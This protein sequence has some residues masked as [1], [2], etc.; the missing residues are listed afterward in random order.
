MPQTTDPVLFRNISSFSLFVQVEDVA[1][2]LETGEPSAI[3]ANLAP[4]E[5][6]ELPVGPAAAWA[7]RGPLRQ[8]VAAGRGPGGGAEVAVDDDAIARLALDPALTTFTNRSGHAAVVFRDDPDSGLTV[9]CDLPIGHYVRQRTHLGERWEV[10]TENEFAPIARLTVTTP[11]ERRCLVE[12][13][14]LGIANESHLHLTVLR[15]DGDHEHAVGHV[16]PRRHLR[17]ANLDPAPLLVRESATGAVVARLGAAAGRRSVAITSHGIRT[18][19]D[20]EPVTLTVANDFAFDL[21]VGEARGTPAARAPGAT[22]VRVAPGAT[23]RLATRRGAL[24]RAHEPLTGVVVAE[25]VVPAPSRARPSALTVARFAPLGKGDSSLGGVPTV[26]IRS[27]YG[28]EN[29]TRLTLALSRVVGGGEEDEGLLRPNEHARLWSEEGDQWVVRDVD[30][31][32]VVLMPQGA[33]DLRFLRIT[34]RMLRSGDSAGTTTVTATNVTPHDLSIRRHDRRGVAKET[35]VIAVGES[36]TFP[37]EPDSV[38]SA[39]ATG[40]GELQANWIARRDLGPQTWAIRLRAPASGPATTVDIHVRAATSVLVAK[41]DEDGDE[42]AVTRL[43]QHD[44][45]PLA[46]RVGDPIIVRDQRSNRVIAVTVAASVPTTLVVTGEDARSTA[47]PGRR[48]TTVTFVNSSGLAADVYWVDWEGKEQHAASLARDRRTVIDGGTTDVFRVRSHGGAVQR[49]P[50]A[51]SAAVVLGRQVG[52]VAWRTASDARPPVYERDLSEVDFRARIDALAAS[53][54][55]VAHMDVVA[56]RTGPRYSAVWEPADGAR[57]TVSLGLT[58]REAIETI[59]ETIGDGAR[60]P[61]RVVG[62]QGADGARFAV[63]FRAVGDAERRGHDLD[64][65]REMFGKAPGY[66]I[67]PTTDGFSAWVY[68]RDNQHSLAVH[69]GVEPAVVDRLIGRDGASLVALSGFETPDG[70]R[71]CAIAQRGVAATAAAHGLDEAAF[72]DRDARERAAGR[73]ITDLSCYADGRDVRHAALWRPAPEDGLPPLT[74]LSAGGLE[75]ALDSGRGGVLDLAYLRQADA[76]TVAVTNTLVR[77]AMRPDGSLRPGEVALFERPNF[78]GRVWI[79]HEDFADFTLLEGMNDVV[80]SLKVGPGTGVTLYRDVSFDGPAA[81][82]H[83]DVPDLGRAGF[84]NGIASSAALWTTPSPAA[85]GIT[86]RSALTNEHR[87][88]RS[89]GQARHVPT[90]VFRA[91]VA[92]PPAVRLVDVWASEPMTIQVAGEAYTIDAQ[93]PARLQP[94]RLSRIVISAPADALHVPELQLRTNTME[95]DQRLPVYLDSSFHRKLA[96]MPTGTLRANRAALNIHADLSDDAVDHVET[97]VRNLARSVQYR[98]APSVNGVHHARHVA[99]GDMEH[100]HWSL[101]FDQPAAGRPDPA[102]TALSTQEAAAHKARWDAAGG[103]L[104]ISVLGPQGI[105]DAFIHSIEN[106]GKTLWSGVKIIAVTVEKEVVTAAET[107]ANV[108]RDGVEMVEHLGKDAVASFAPF[109][110]DLVHGDL[111]H[112]ANDLGHG[113]LNFGAHAA[114][115]VVDGVVNVAED[116]GTGLAEEAG[117]LLK[118]SEQ[119]LALGLKFGAQEVHIMA[120]ELGPISTLVTSLLDWAGAGVGN[121]VRHM[122]TDVDWHEAMRI[123]QELGAHTEGFLTDAAASAAAFQAQGD[124]FFA[125]AAHQIGDELDAAAKALDP[126]VRLHRSPPGGFSEVMET[127]ESILSKLADPDDDGPT[128]LP[129]LDLSA[130][131]TLSDP[132][133]RMIAHMEATLGQEG[134]KLEALLGD[135]FARISDLLGS[136]HASTNQI[137]AELLELVKDVDRA[138][139]SIVGTTF[140]LAMEAVE[141]TFGILGTALAERMEVPFFSGLY[142][143]LTAGETDLGALNLGALLVAIPAAMMAD[144]LDKSPLGLGVSLAQSVPPGQTD[145]PDVPATNEAS[146]LPAEERIVVGFGITYAACHAVLGLLEAA[147]TVNGMSGVEDLKAVRAGEQARSFDRVG[148]TLSL[149]SLVPSITSQVVANPTERPCGPP[150]FAGLEP[151]NGRRVLRAP[152]YVAHVTWVLQIVELVF[153]A[154]ERIAVAFDSGRGNGKGGQARQDL[155]EGAAGVSDVG[156]GLITLYGLAHLVCFIVLR[157]RDDEKAERLSMLRTFRLEGLS[158]RDLLESLE[159]AGLQISPEDRAE[160]VA[161]LQDPKLLTDAQV[162]ELIGDYTAFKQWADR[163]DT[164]GLKLAANVMDSVP[165][166]GAFMTIERVMAAAPEI[167][168]PLALAVIGG[169]HLAEAGAYAVRLQQDELRYRSV[170][171]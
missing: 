61:D 143:A 132:L 1:A 53:S 51:I 169:G 9:V 139:L 141:G 103:A 100:A 157:I 155:L 105:F 125:D 62:Y 3:G 148:A 8:E 122:L 23:A 36:L 161:R 115:D 92:F 171:S 83:L 144:S 102:Y 5:E 66:R 158:G 88:D 135:G 170:P 149:V 87:V 108:A 120:T 55:Q 109:A 129:D 75:A 60:L 56:T 91:S 22:T 39:V 107:V 81:S 112:A 123:A 31:G 46:C 10:L 86:S 118:E 163:G 134:E 138:G 12:N 147:N 168:L 19:E 69:A 76:Q 117:H 90:P 48:A 85:L 26:A 154:L 97:A 150:S 151:I 89:S 4:G 82:F 67:I 45:Y 30:S 54:L 119:M 78:G 133:G 6:R 77:T 50:G 44:S 130:A 70:V 35:A 64:K 95:S 20:A 106:V 18:A 32:R 43:D 114:E 71:M 101:S 80:A 38:W 52:A 29:R 128:T 110:E 99:A 146:D 162:T 49:R 113:L 7:V 33:R 47:G 2:E 136:E 159:T 165:E 84:L 42:I 24:I 74:G 11:G 15:P 34:P 68:L 153:E 121:L 21:D 28:F 63:S 41:A 104:P 111:A 140:D 98:A 164:A 137:T 124:T 57:R 25:T 65:V 152:A 116:V 73:V 93:K 127:V 145:V 27:R 160:I 58:A 96:A 17:V 14:L 156:K 166:I 59:T 126:S 37:A 142:E 167:M 13:T 131:G 72:R 16:A 40:T 79:L 94:N